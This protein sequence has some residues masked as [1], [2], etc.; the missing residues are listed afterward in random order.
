MS[1]CCSKMDRDRQ[2]FIMAQLVIIPV[3]PFPV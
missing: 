1:L 3:D 2:V